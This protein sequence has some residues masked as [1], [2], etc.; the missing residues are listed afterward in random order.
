MKL[1]LGLLVAAATKIGCAVADEPSGC[2]QALYSA[3]PG[4]SEADFEDWSVDTHSFASASF[5]AGTQSLRLRGGFFPGQGHLMYY[6]SSSNACGHGELMLTASMFSRDLEGSNK[7]SFDVSFDGGSTWSDTLM[8]LGAGDDQGASVRQ[9]FQ[10]DSGAPVDYLLRLSLDA[11]DFWDFCFLESVYVG[12]PFTTTTTTTTEATTTTPPRADDCTI[13]VELYSTHFANSAQVSAWS[14]GSFGFGGLQLTSSGSSTYSVSS[15][16]EAFHEVEVFAVVQG[17]RLSQGDSCKVKVSFDGGQTLSD[18]VVHVD[19]AQTSVLG[20]RAI[21][22]EGDVPAWDQGV[23]LVLVADVSGNGRCVLHAAGVSGHNNCNDC[24]TTCGGYSC[25]DWL[26]MNIDMTCDHL[27]MLSCECSGCRCGSTTTTTS[28]TSTSSSTTSTSS[29]TELCQATCFD[30]SCD[31]Y[32][33]NQGYTCEAL[34]EYDC[35]C[36]G[37]SCITT[38]ASTTT[39]DAPTTSTVETTSS[40]TSTTSTSTSTST[41]TTEEGGDCPE[42]CHG[43]SCDFWGVDDGTTCAMAEASGCDCSGCEC[44]ATTTTSTNVAPQ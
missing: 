1:V 19:A 26:D 13:P 34:E 18:D 20:R 22:A 16:L 44:L 21:F 35:N 32:V 27:E 14:T 29:T 43:Y 9:T 40:S 30:Y 24:P 25:D 36:N 33:E 41:T 31:Y 37:C 11:D 17:Y 12:P 6:G 4:A 3:G 2:D 7:C 8:M 15:D 5:D 39:T 38:T 10:V 42:T 28:T 23:E